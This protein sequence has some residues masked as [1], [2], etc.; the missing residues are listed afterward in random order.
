[1]LP[2]AGL[3]LRNSRYYL[4]SCC[5]RCGLVASDCVFSIVLKDITVHL[6]EFM[7]HM[8]Q[9]KAYSKNFCSFQHF[10]LFPLLKQMHVLLDSLPLMF[11]QFETYHE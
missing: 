11:M 10:F 6:Y 1:M 5:V 8:R 7:L 3:Q 4:G 2:T 9:S